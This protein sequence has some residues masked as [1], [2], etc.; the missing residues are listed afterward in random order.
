VILEGELTKLTTIDDIQLP[1]SII[2][3][4]PSGRS[5]LRILFADLD[6]NGDAP[7]FS[8]TIPANARRSTRPHP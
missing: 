3:R 7:D 1:R 2:L 4:A 6:V 8:Y 5:T